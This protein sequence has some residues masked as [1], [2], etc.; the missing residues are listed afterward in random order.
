MGNIAANKMQTHVVELCQLAGHRRLRS[1]A[2]ND[3]DPSR[4]NVVAAGQEAGEN[5]LQ[6]A[7]SCST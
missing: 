5:T 2:N 6:I 4:K 1:F 3:I 7:A